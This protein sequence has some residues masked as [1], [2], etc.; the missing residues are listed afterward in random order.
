MNKPAPTHLQAKDLPA[1]ADGEDNL[2]QQIAALSPAGAI[3]KGRTSYLPA[4][5]GTERV[6][7]WAI[8]EPAQTDNL[9]ALARQLTTTAHLMMVLRVEREVLRDRSPSDNRIGLI[10]QAL[11]REEDHMHRIAEWTR[12]AT[13]DG[14][15][16]KDN[17]T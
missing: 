10:D 9:N 5:F 7:R 6:S 2:R 14:P 15:L 17:G 1:V 3:S 4:V 13:F 11:L 16:V 12:A 8:A